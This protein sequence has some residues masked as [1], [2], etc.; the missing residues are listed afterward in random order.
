MRLVGFEGYDTGVAMGNDGQL[1][2]ISDPEIAQFYIAQ[3]EPR[4]M[5]IAIETD[6]V[7]LGATIR[8]LV[9][10]S[11]EIDGLR[12]GT[13]V[14]PGVGCGTFYRNRRSSP[15]GDGR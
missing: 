9:A 10:G 12:V 8:I 15:S 7:L 2:V 14:Y 4:Q 1:F 3:N 13:G 6:Q 5:D 11:V